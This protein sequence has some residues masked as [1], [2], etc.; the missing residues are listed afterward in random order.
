MI[1][2]FIKK[3]DLTEL[4]RVIRIFG[5]SIENFNVVHFH[6]FI[7]THFSTHISTVSLQFHFHIPWICSDSVIILFFSL[8]LC[9][10]KCIPQNTVD[11]LHQNT[12]KKYGFVNI[13]CASLIYLYF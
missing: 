10:P 4:T 3:E 6:S 1:N 9:G 12:G 7:S 13:N 2:T 8:F 5:I 11:I